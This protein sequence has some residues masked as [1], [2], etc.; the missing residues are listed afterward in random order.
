M[1]KEVQKLR[2]E[3]QGLQLKRQPFQN[4]E[5]PNRNVTNTSEMLK[6]DEIR[7]ILMR[8]LNYFEP[9]MNMG[10][11]QGVEALLEQFR[12][13]SQLYSEPYLQ[14]KLIEELV[15]GVVRTTS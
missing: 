10:N 4:T 15:P 1:Q 13:N 12:H 7:P 2:E 14:L 9:D 5:K 8:L 6:H 11:L 3:T